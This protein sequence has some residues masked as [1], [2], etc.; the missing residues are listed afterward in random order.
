MQIDDVDTM[1]AQP[2]DAA[3][4]GDRFAHHHSADIE[5]PHQ[6]A[7]VPAWRQRGDHDGVLVAALATSLAECIGLAVHGRVVFLHAAVMAAAKQ[8]SVAVV[9]RGPDRD[10]AFGQTL[11]GFGDGGVEQRAVVGCGDHASS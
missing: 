1:L 4:E 3:L 5:L 10:A 11:A 7:A 6:P 8:T 9:Q 2:V